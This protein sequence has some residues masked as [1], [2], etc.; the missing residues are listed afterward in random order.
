M[1]QTMG[2]DI[3]TTAELMGHSDVETTQVYGKIIDTKKISAVYMIDRL[4]D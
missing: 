2:A 1:T 3:Y 4:F